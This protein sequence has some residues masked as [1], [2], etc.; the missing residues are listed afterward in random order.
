MEF[1]ELENIHLKFKKNIEVET[2]S[3]Y[4]KSLFRFKRNIKENNY[5]CQS[6]FNYLNA[7]L[8]MF[9]NW[10]VLNEEDFKLYTTLLKNIK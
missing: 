7:Y 3:T 1:K 4:R 2:W 6:E 9:F 8:K 10:G 5:F